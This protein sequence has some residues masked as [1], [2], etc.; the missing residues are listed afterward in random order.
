MLS[1]IMGQGGP[2]LGHTLCCQTELS[3]YDDSMH[4][5]W[6]MSYKYH[7][8]AIVLNEKNLVLLW[9]VAYAGNVGCKDN[10]YVNW[11]EDTEYFQNKTHCCPSMMVMAFVL[12]DGYKADNR[13]RRNWPSPVVFHDNGKDTSNMTVDPGS[14]SRFID[15]S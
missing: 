9:D 1:I 2:E 7:K 3:C 11:D 12:K 10:T 15:T 5:I 14:T 6:G 13:F 4:G 8:L